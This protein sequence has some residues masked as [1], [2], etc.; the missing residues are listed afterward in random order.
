VPARA[1]EAAY[2]VLSDDEERIGFSYSGFAL[3]SLPHKPVNDLSWKREGH[4]LT[5]LVQSAS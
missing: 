2:Q 1:T 5:L 3:T 4:N